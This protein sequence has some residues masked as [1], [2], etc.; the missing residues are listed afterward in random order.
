MA[1]A[2]V[3]A[4]HRV[5]GAAAR[6]AAGAPDLSASSR[7]SKIKAVTMTGDC[8]PY[9]QYGKYSGAKVTIYTS[10]TNPELQYHIDA[11]KQFESAPA[12]R[13]S[14]RA[15]RTSRAS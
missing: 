5:D 4:G 14:T 1:V 13:S 2:A 3:T 15:P 11:I 8:A 10:I 7:Q 6:A 9:G 12:S